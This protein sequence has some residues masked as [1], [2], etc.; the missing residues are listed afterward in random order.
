VNTYDDTTGVLDHYTYHRVPIS[1]ARFHEHLQI[2]VHDGVGG[3]LE[4]SI[5]GHFD[6]QGGHADAQSGTTTNQ[7]DSRGNLVGQSISNPG[8]ARAR[9]LYYDNDGQSSRS[10]RTSI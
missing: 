4:K 3:L 5:G 6:E 1:Q 9:V 2:R 8:H 7:Y 10:P